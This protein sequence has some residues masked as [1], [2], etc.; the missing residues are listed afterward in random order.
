MRSPRPIHRSTS[1]P[2][3]TLAMTPVMALARS[4]AMMVATFATSVGIGSTDAGRR[5]G[6]A[7]HVAPPLLQRPDGGDETIGAQMAG[8]DTMLLGRRTYQEFAAHW[9]SQ[10]SDAPFADYMNTTPKLVVSTTLGTLEW[11]NSTLIT[12]NVVQELTKLKQQQPGKNQHLRQRHPGA[13]AA[14]R[15]PAPRRVPA[16]DLPDRRGQ[17]QAPVR[18]WGAAEARGRNDLQHGGPVTHLRAG[19]PVA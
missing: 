14:T 7:R 4:E 3:V 5:R 10:P 11:Q 18:G 12:G 19:R 13:V 8:A 15:G 1:A 17:R 9:P 2:Q 16:H 6:G